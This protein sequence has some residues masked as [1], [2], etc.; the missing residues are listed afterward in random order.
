MIPDDT[1]MITSSASAHCA[2]AEANAV[3][4]DSVCVVMA[5]VVLLDP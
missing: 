1:H 3:T 2:A 5:T 4:A